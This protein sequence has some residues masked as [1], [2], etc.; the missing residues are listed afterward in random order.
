MRA[1]VV[2]NVVGTTMGAL[3]LAG[4]LMASPPASSP[5]Y[6]TVDASAWNFQKEASHLLA[7][8][9]VFSGELRKDGD[10]LESFRLSNLSWQTHGDQLTRAKG[11]INAMGERLER[12]QEIRHVTAPWQQQA[13]DRMVPVAAEIASRTQAAIEHLNENRGYLFALT[14][15]DHLTTIA[16]QARRLDDSA[17]AFVEYGNTQEKLDQLQEDLEIRAS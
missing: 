12:L 13:I 4:S 9:R 8:V 10:Q 7:E 17:R 2:R 16:E 15:T 11:H 5:D 3:L 1:N 6:A 14:Y